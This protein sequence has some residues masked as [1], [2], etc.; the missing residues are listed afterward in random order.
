M[1]WSRFVFLCP[2]FRLL[3]FM[4]AAAFLIP[5]EAVAQGETTSAI[6]GDVRDA[7]GALV[8]GAV[9]TIT[10]GEI[11]LKRTAKTDGAGRFNFP[12][13]KPGSYSVK[14]EAEGFAPQ[15]DE[16]VLAGF[17]QKHTINF[18]LKLAQSSE[19]V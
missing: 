1:P 4:V 10:N 5:A 18:T 11:G 2:V 17:G 7:S 15:Q 12:Q 14:V 19:T 16:N 13:L 6:I 9:L 3:L 8:P